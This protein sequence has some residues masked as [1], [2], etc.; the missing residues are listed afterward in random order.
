MLE[1]IN[2]ILGRK[3]RAEKREIL[4]MNCNRNVWELLENKPTK[5]FFVTKQ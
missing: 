3:E 1:I 5:H 4:K 2:G